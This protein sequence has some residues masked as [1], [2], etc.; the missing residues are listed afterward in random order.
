MTTVFLSGSRKIGRLNNEIRDRLS[1]IVAK[2]LSVVLGDANGADKA[3]Q[4]FFAEIGY[5]DVTV[6]CSGDV[7]RNNFGRWKERNVEVGP[8]VKGRRFY[9]EKDKRMAD[10]ADYG[11]LLW[12]GKSSG[13]LM[14]LIELL[15]RNK[16]ALVYLAPK[17]QFYSVCSVSDAHRLFESC[18][19]Q[20]KIS[21]DN[22]FKASGLPLSMESVT[23]GTFSF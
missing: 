1:N 17:K 4:K 23:Q 15:K 11:F 10:D 19:N 6:Y 16:K 14:N 9:T 5:A 12:D 8:G 7:C 18:D 3:M 20:I 22:D 21:A 2:N 13:T